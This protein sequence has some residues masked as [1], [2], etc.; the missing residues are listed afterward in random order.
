M[1]VLSAAAIRTV[2]LHI[3]MFL[4]SNHYFSFKGRHLR[5]FHTKVVILPKQLA[6]DYTN[7]KLQKNDECN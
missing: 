2:I 1:A 3:A 6:Q 7:L 4:D 5:I